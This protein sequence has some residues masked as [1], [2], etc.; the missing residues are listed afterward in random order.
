MKLREWDYE[1]GP[2]GGWTEV[3]YPD[4]LVKAFV[5]WFRVN[6]QW[7]ERDDTGPMVFR[8]FKRFQDNLNDA[9]NDAARAAVRDPC[10]A[11]T[12]A[13]NP[14]KNT[15]DVVDGLCHIHRRTLAAV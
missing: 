3:E 10:T 11:L 4:D 14:C 15:V 8:H 5:D 7:R 9:K 2:S 12:A 13:G 6:K 1:F